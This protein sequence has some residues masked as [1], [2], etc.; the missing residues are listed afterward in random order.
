[1]E[2]STNLFHGTL[3][4]LKNPINTIYIHYI[5]IKKQT[6]VITSAR[7]AL[8]FLQSLEKYFYL[9]CFSL[10][11]QSLKWKHLTQLFRF[12]KQNLGKASALAISQVW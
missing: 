7:V 10:L 1:M 4:K 11:L 12:V 2:R 6:N 9:K 3:H 5:Y 8:C